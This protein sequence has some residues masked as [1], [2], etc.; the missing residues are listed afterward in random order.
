[1]TVMRGEGAK[2][3]F[4]SVGRKNADTRRSYEADMDRT[5]LFHD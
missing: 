2:P 1:M 3:S 5:F 4:F